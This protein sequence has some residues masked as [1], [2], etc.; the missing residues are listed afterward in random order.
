MSRERWSGCVPSMG[1]SSWLD[2]A[3]SGPAMSSSTIC[4]SIVWES[5]GSVD[6]VMESGSEGGSA[7]CVRQDSWRTCVCSTWVDPTASWSSCLF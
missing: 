3:F 6:C 5:A 7:L 2:L 1:T 4:V